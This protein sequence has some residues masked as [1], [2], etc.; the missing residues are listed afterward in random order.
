MSNLR[1]IDIY[2]EWP[3]IEVTAHLFYKLL[4]ERDENVNISHHEMPTWEKHIAFIFGRPYERWYV[5][6][7]DG[8]LVGSCY[9]TKQNE[10][11]IHILKKF[12]GL[13]YGPEAVKMLME[14]HGERRYLANVAPR[15]ERGADMFKEFGFTLV[16]HTYAFPK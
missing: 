8:A 10:I 12:H 7:V 15:N 6:E 14:R 13:G 3:A 5:V 1:L 11:G 2:G 16:Q 4:Q 9:L